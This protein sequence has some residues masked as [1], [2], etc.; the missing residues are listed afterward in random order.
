M[1][2]EGHSLH[3][4]FGTRFRGHMKSWG[5]NK[6]RVFFRAPGLDDWLVTF[7]AQDGRIRSMHVQESPWAPEWYDDRD[8]LGVFV[9][10]RGT[11][12]SPG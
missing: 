3:L 12:K 11:P 9:S 4:H 5:E 6:F 8:N 2:E 10:T 7:T 1:V